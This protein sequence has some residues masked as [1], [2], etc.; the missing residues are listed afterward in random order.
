MKEAMRVLCRTS[1]LLAAC[2]CSWYFLRQWF[3]PDA[4]MD[5]GAVFDYKK[6]ECNYAAENLPYIE[7]PALGLG[8]FWLALSSVVIAAA[9]H[10]CVGRRAN[11]A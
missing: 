7:V 10:V 9:V 3:A 2:A 11:A 8:S 6:W 1:S 4:C 5:R